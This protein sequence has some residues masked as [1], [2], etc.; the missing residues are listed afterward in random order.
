MGPLTEGGAMQH[1]RIAVYKFRS[2]AADEVIAKAQ[3]GLLP[4]YRGQAGFVG[5]GVAKTAEDAGVSIS[6]WQTQ[7]QAEAAVQIAGTW[8]RDNIASLV[9]SVQNHVGDLSFFS[10]AGSLGS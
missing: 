10:S 4:I 9:E 7:A 1:V 3:A 2:G 6:V 8:V 5:Y